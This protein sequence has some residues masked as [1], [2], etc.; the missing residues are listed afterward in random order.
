M[1]HFCVCVIA[2]MYFVLEQHCE[3][4]KVHFSSLAKGS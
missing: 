4:E 1:V 3:A 2:G